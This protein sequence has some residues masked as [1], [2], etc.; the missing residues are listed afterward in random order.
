MKRIGDKIMKNVHIGVQMMTILPMERWNARVTRLSAARLQ[1]RKLPETE[2]GNPHLRQFSRTPPSSRILQVWFYNVLHILIHALVLLRWRTLLS[3][4]PRRNHSSCI[5]INSPRG[6]SGV[7][8]GLFRLQH[9]SFFAS[10]AST[11]PK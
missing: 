4:T 11:I 5:S 1:R 3:C 8:D 6:I 7:D 2:A 9:P 10:L